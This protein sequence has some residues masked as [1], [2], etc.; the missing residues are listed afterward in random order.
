MHTCAGRG[1]RAFPPPHTPPH[2]LNSHSENQSL[3]L[4]TEKKNITIRASS[5]GARRF[6]LLV[7]T[8][9]VSGM[10]LVRELESSTIMHNYT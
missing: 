2:F 7:L 3:E 6:D 1:P 4:A 8:Y 9:G 5:Y 10:N